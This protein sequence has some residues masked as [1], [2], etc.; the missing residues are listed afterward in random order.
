MSWVT[1]LL[2]TSVKKQRDLLHSSDQIIKA[3]ADVRLGPSD[4][5]LHL[6]VSGFYT[7]GTRELLVRH[8][9]ALN[10]QRFRQTSRNVLDVLLWHQHS[11][12]KMLPDKHPRVIVGFRIS[13]RH[14]A[15]VPLAFSCMPWSMSGHHARPYTTKVAWVGPNGISVLHL[16]VLKNSKFGR[17]GCLA[18]SLLMESTQRLQ[19][20]SST[21]ACFVTSSEE[22]RRRILEAG[23]GRIV[24]DYLCAATQACIPTHILV[25]WSATPVRQRQKPNTLWPP[26]SYHP[27]RTLRGNNAVGQFNMRY[28]VG[29]AFNCWPVL[30]SAVRNWIVGR[31]AGDI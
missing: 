3:I 23:V 18:V 14:S 4:A 19:R 11:G 12:T 5:F 20:H 30:A 15:M 22:P 2:S 27:I 29:F 7:K 28:S 25:P 6:A 31:A 13:L 10:P 26:S 17:S 24:V 1:L 16:Y 21:R 8:C 9:S